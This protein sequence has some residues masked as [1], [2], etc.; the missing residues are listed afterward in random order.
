MSDEK[1]SAEELTKQEML[2]AV[3]DIDSAFKKIGKRF[4]TIATGG[5]EEITSKLWK[6]NVSKVKSSIQG[7]KES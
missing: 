3:D 1:P 5:L 2:G 7:T 6:R 4:I